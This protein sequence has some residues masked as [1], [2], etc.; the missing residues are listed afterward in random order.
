MKQ[1]WVSSG[2][3][4]WGMVFD[5]LWTILP[6]SCPQIVTVNIHFFKQMRHFTGAPCCISYQFCSCRHLNEIVKELS[7][8]PP[9]MRIFFSLVTVSLR[10]GGHAKMK[11][12]PGAAAACPSQPTAYPNNG[13][14]KKIYLLL[15]Y[16]ISFLNVYI[17]I[18]AAYSY[19]PYLKRWQ[20][21]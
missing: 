2:I 9:G 17:I 3:S 12:N 13:E 4:L 8:A 16:Y 5:I 21:R 11:E 1:T 10:I 7:S 15:L 20:S 6:P 19:T 18:Y 14:W